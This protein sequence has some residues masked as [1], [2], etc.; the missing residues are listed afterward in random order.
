MAAAKAEGYPTHGIDIIIGFA[1]GGTTDLVSRIAATYLSKKWGVPINII[2][3][4][5]GNSVP[6]TLDVYNAAP[7][8]YTLL[9]DAIGSASMMAVDVPNLPFKVM[10]RTFV[11]IISV[12]PQVIF[13]PK[14]SPINNLADLVAEAKKD[15]STFTWVGAGVASIPLRQLLLATGVDIK[16]T[17]NIS[18]PGA[19][20]AAVLAASGDVK[21]GLSAVG[22]M[23]SPISAGLI[24]PIAVA[25][26]ERV[27]SLPDVPTAIEQGFPTVM[28]DSWIALTGPPGLPDE[29]IA[30]WN[31]GIK[32]MDSD[33]EV[34]DKLKNLASVPHFTNSADFR[35]QVASEID[36]FSVLW[37]A[38]GK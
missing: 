15:P 1:P 14:N 25:S 23:L 9:G 29:V 17:K 31:E 18:S 13:V 19:V 4:P 27:P 26:K 12:N 34:L 30:K 24:K 33:P 32:E 5:G 38:A 20:S 21:V 36:N 3:K 7:D 8:G 10:D 28:Q 22:P 35:A 2:N 16:Q 6:A 37:K 11:N